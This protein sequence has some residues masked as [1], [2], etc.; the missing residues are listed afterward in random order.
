MTPST[1]N[2][3]ENLL[4][5]IGESAPSKA[6]PMQPTATDRDE[7]RQ[8]VINAGTNVGVMVAKVL[9]VFVVSPILVHGLGD[10]RYG[11][12]MFVSSITAYLALGDLG[13]KSAVMR[14]VARYDGLHD[15]DGINRVVNTSSAI[16]L[17]IGVIIL[18]IT[19][20]AGYFWRSPPSIPTELAQETRWFFVLSGILVAMLLLVSIPQSLLAGLGRFPMRNGI[21]LISLFLRHGALVAVVWCGGGLVAVGVVLV[22][23]C[24]VDFGMAHW[25]ARRC[26]PRLVYSYRYVD[27]EMFRIVC[28]YGVHVFAGDIA[29]LVT[30]QSAALIIGAIL[31]SPD[32][33]T[34]FSLGATLKDNAL[35]ILAMVVFVL[36]PAVS[37]WQAAGNDSAIRSLLIH[38]TRYALYFIAPI[39]FGLLI[40]GHSFLKLWMGP[41]YA[42]AGYM[43]LVILSAPLLLIAIAMVASRV[44]TGIGK[45]RQLA[46]F[47]AMQAVL[48]VVLGVALAYPLGIEGVAW[49]VSLGMIPAAIATIILACRSVQVKVVTLL[50]QASWGPL[51]AS[52]VAGL[53]WIVAK[54]GFPTNNWAAFLGVGIL[55][56]VPYSIIVIVLEPDVRRLSG[57]MARRSIVLFFWALR[58][59]ASWRG[60]SR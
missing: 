41:R 53:I 54:Q 43:T 2:E 27:R 38:A 25:A 4:E 58:A 34:Y 33:I 49:G 48:T 9:V 22:A 19:F 14:F 56:M 46:I 51:S 18:A 28:G 10:T 30:V 37:K 16:L 50:R 47:T 39:E 40:F 31:C 32:Y 11:V 57:S 60:F 8:V 52:A 45:V 35:S 59:S 1:F 3:D 13:V 12:W 36:I 17:C 24:V 6:A 42:D 26:F 5:E 29:Y 44:L 23:N 55:G 7:H 15:R 20:L 21:S